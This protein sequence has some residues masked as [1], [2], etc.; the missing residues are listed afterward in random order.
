MQGEANRP[1]H[2]V[3]FVL[4]RGALLTEGLCNPT[5]RGKQC[6]TSY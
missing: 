4:W 2:R 3:G 5:Q 1:L 6:E